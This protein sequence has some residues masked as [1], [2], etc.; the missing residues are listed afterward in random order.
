M[1]G[2]FKSNIVLYFFDMTK[3]ELEPKPMRVTLSNVRNDLTPDEI[4][5]VAAAFDSLVKHTMGDIEFIQFS[6]VI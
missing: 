3:G 4:K 1:L 5:Q 6:R 2:N